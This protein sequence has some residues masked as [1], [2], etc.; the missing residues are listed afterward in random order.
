[1]Y[2]S[3]IINI[4]YIFAFTNTLSANNKDFLLEI[5]YILVLEDVKCYGLKRT[6]AKQAYWS[7]TVAIH[8]HNLFRRL[9]IQDNASA[10][11]IPLYVSS[12]EKDH[13][14]FLLPLIKTTT[15]SNALLRLLVKST[16][17]CSDP[18][19]FFRVSRLFFTMYLPI[20]VY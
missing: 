13:R 6:I 10:R 20:N 19:K 2:Y 7:D 16:I 4:L 14:I 3:F 12:F 17:S 11:V 1:M 5:E 18:F 15:L 8:G 9:I